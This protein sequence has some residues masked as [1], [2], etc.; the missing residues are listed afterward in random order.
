M[1]CI[2][3]STLI[4][5]FEIFPFRFYI[6]ELKSDVVSMD[7]VSSKHQRV[8]RSQHSMDPAW[9]REK[10]RERRKGQTGTEKKEKEEET[11]RKREGQEEEEK[12]PFTT[13]DVLH[14]EKRNHECGQAPKPK[15]LRKV[16]LL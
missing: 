10:G 8:L 9:G 5:T 6:P 15:H 12:D 1:G 7:E 2:C 14:F 16:V 4:N 3:A 11:G 13:T